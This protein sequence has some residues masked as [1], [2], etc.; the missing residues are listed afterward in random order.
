MVQLSGARKLSDVSLV[1]Q[2]DLGSHFGWQHCI[3]ALVSTVVSPVLDA[4]LR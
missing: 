3:A 1:N 2:M 4:N